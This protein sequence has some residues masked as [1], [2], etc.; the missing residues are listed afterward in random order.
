MAEHQKF[1]VATQLSLWFNSPSLGSVGTG[2]DSDNYG[3]T[4]RVVDFKFSAPI[5]RGLRGLL[6][7]GNL[8]D[9]ES[10]AGAATPA[11]P[12]GAFRTRCIHGT[13][14]RCGLAAAMRPACPNRP[15]AGLLPEL[16]LPAQ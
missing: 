10:C 1:G 5:A 6:E 9:G 16:N 3:D 11:S 8:N 15:A 7:I 12:R 2:P 4:Y 13:L 14:R